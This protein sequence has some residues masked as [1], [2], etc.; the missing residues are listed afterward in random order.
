MKKRTEIESK[1]ST[2]ASNENK[3]LV[4]LS[5]EAHKLNAAK[6]SIG[7]QSI[8]V[9]NNSLISVQNY[10]DNI[11][12]YN[13][14]WSILVDKYNNFDEAKINSILDKQ[15]E[16][17]TG[18]YYIGENFADYMDVV[19]DSIYKQPDNNLAAEII[20]RDYKKDYG[21]T[22]LKKIS[23]RPEANYCHIYTKDRKIAAEFMIWSYDKYIMPK[24]NK[25]F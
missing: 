23:F 10:I 20:K 12:K 19:N 17:K 22:K 3:E 15:K 2:T 11:I 13:S 14:Y 9:D 5:I 4:K 8:I 21:A 7:N 6:F 18:L 16:N 1:S 24:I 25:L